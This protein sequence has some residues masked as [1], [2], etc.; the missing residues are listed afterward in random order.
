MS[1]LT[2]TPPPFAELG[3]AVDAYTEMSLLCQGFSCKLG[4]QVVTHSYS[5]TAAHTRTTQNPRIHEFGT[6]A[7]HSTL[8]CTQRRRIRAANT[9]Y[10]LV[11]RGSC[12][13]PHGSIPAPVR[14]EA[15]AAC[16]L[17]ICHSGKARG[18]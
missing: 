5:S 1:L 14:V 9:T 17:R 16:L 3:C 18:G 11:T 6:E 13:V 2:A 10:S 8:I 4:P 7:D 12:V 15:N